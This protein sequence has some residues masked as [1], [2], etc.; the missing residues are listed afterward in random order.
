MAAS[1][2]LAASS[3]G[4]FRLIE[5]LVEWCHSLR[6][7]RGYSLRCYVRVAELFDVGLDGL[8]VAGID[9]LCQAVTKVADTWED[10]FL[11]GLSVISA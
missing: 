8:D 6:W 9:E 4:V 11:L 1:Y 5:P 10:E 3:D 7:G 2:S